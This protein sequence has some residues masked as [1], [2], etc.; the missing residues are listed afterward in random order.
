ML[1]HIANRFMSTRMHRIE[2]KFRGHGWA[3]GEILKIK[4][5]KITGRHRF[6]L[7][8]KMEFDEDQIKQCFRCPEEECIP[9]TVIQRSEERSEVSEP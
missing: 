9:R 3:A 4:R 8:F 2:K 5:N 1:L 6:I 7:Q